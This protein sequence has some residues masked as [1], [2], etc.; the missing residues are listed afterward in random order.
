MQHPWALIKGLYDFVIF[1]MSAEQ[2]MLKFS[3][4]LPKLRVPS[5]VQLMAIYLDL[6]ARRPPPHH[7]L[8]KVLLIIS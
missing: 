4:F 7:I 2:V 6:N 3:V 8:F 5:G 1:R